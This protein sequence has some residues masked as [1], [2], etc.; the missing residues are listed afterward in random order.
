LH[1]DMPRILADSD[2]VEQKRR[3]LPPLVQ[4]GA[5]CGAAAGLVIFFVTGEPAIKYITFGPFVRVCCVPNERGAAVALVGLCGL[6]VGYAAQ[7]IVDIVKS[8]R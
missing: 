6:A 3:A 5:L 1:F 4:A 8:R 2:P 7:W